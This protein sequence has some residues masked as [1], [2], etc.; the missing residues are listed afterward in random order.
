M[1]LSLVVAWLVL[2]GCSP[3]DDTVSRAGNERAPITAS[4]RGPRVAEPGSI[5]LELVIERRVPASAELSIA[6][7]LP[8]GARLVRGRLRERLAGPRALRRYELAVERLPSE[9]F[10]VVLDAQS[11]G[12][13]YHAE[14][15]YRF[16]RSAP[17]PQVPRL[18]ERSL[19]LGSR[20]FGRSVR[21]TTPASRSR[22]SR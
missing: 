20:S 4:L 5:E 3:H 12:F 11:P 17:L 14:L 19:T 13:G 21:V 2:A 7:R 1:R 10:V 15:P 8:G 6:L 18:A 16:G 9:D 22:P